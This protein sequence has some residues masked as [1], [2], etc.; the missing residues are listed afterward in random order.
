MSV[1]RELVERTSWG[2]PYCGHRLFCP[3]PA[4]ASHLQALVDLYVESATRALLLA[5]NHA[6][7]ASRGHVPRRN[8]EGA[9]AY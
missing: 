2:K 4:Q 8:R 1:D 6:N 5:G 9:R 3:S 7:A